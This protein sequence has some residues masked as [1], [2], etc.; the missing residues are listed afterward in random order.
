ME[1]LNADVGPRSARQFRPVEGKGTAALHYTGGSEVG[2]VIASEDGA[3]P[4]AA[5]QDFK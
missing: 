5:Q 1:A 3:E 2:P 4:T